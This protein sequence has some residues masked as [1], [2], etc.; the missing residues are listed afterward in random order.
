MPEVMQEFRVK[1]NDGFWLVYL[2][3]IFLCQ[4]IVI[5]SH[6]FLPIPQKY[7]DWFF[8]PFGLIYLV[9]VVTYFVMMAK[10]RFLLRM[11]SSHLSIGKRQFDVKDG[12]WIRTIS[13]RRG[14]LT[15]SIR[16]KNKRFPRMIITVSRQDAVAVKRLV[17]VWNQQQKHDDL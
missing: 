17:Q 6:L 9:S 14:A 12:W 10:R 4:E 13:L 15:L 11:T 3:L 1:A 2:F 8:I 7:W 5:L 16:H